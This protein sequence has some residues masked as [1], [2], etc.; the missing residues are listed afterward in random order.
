ME[1]IILIIILVFFIVILYNKEKFFQTQ[2]RNTNN[3]TNVPNTTN[4]PNTT[5]MPITN[6]MPTTTKM[7]IQNSLQIIDFPNNIDTIYDSISFNLKLSLKSEL[8][9]RSSWDNIYM[10][11]IILNN[12]ENYVL[13]NTPQTEQYIS[14]SHL[15]NSNNLKQ[16]VFINKYNA[17]WGGILPTQINKLSDLIPWQDRPLD[18][19]VSFLFQLKIDKKIK[20]ETIDFTHNFR[21]GNKKLLIMLVDAQL[22]ENY[23]ESNIFNKYK[24]YSQDSHNFKLNTIRDNISKINVSRFSSLAEEE[25]EEQE[26]E[27]EQ[28]EEPSEKYT[29]LVYKENFNPYEKILFKTTDVKNTPKLIGFKNAIPPKIDS[30]TSIYPARKLEHVWDYTGVHKAPSETEKHNGIDSAIE[31]R[32]INIFYHPMNYVL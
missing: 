25:E 9:T 24:I 31:K 23:D 11:C 2:A 27:E 12:V 5:E 13:G 21:R 1:I 19:S 7:P 22:N 16:S 20:N 14:L 4:M 6:N 3:T 10:F 18:N 17:G 15:D 29:G 32:P 28:M 8:K 30:E 26:T